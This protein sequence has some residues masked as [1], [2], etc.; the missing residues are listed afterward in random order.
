MRRIWGSYDLCVYAIVIESAAQSH[1]HRI[2]LSAV[3]G[4]HIGH[5]TLHR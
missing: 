5:D 3:G 4:I 1:L 2:F